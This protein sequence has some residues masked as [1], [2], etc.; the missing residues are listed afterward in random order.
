MPGGAIILTSE[1]ELATT[2]LSQLA[3]TM[4]KRHAHNDFITRSKLSDGVLTRRVADVEQLED[5]LHYGVPALLERGRAGLGHPGKSGGRLMGFKESGGI[6]EGKHG[7]PQSTGSS[8]PSRQLIAP[9]SRNYRNPRLGPVAPI[10]HQPPPAPQPI[11][12]LVLDSLTALLRGAETPYTSSSAGM[13]A[14][15]RHLCSVGDKLKALA[16]EYELAVVV[17]NQVSDVFDRRPVARPVDTDETDTTH[18]N[19]RPSQSQHPSSS[20]SVNLTHDQA[21]YA[22][23]PD[24]P[25]LYA[26]QARWFSGQGSNGKKEAALGVVWAN[27]VNT[28]VMLSRTG[29]RRVVEPEE[30]YQKGGGQD[31]GDIAWEK[32]D[33]QPDQAGQELQRT[34]VRRAHLVFSPFAPPG[35]VDYIIRPAGITGLRDTY[36]LDEDGAKVLART[37]ERAEREPDDTIEGGEVGQGGPQ[38]DMEDDLFGPLNGLDDVPEEWWNGNVDGEVLGAELENTTVVS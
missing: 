16:V 25:L 18:P 31:G 19:K 34:L 4:Q 33:E 32:D 11:R 10:A 35:T 36:T 5:V 6:E 28:R 9:V 26:T 37:K 7:R 3:H 2:R 17:I 20:Q 24:P 21:W 30:V 12:L 14:R 38:G 23:G 1:R 29:R 8:T 13:T 15:S 22:A 27:T